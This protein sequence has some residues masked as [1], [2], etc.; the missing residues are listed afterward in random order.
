LQFLDE[1][2]HRLGAF[3]ATVRA[4]LVELDLIEFH[5]GG[6]D[7]VAEVDHDLVSLV[8]VG[9]IEQPLARLGIGVDEGAS[10]ILVLLEP[11]AHRGEAFLRRAGNLCKQELAAGLFKTEAVTREQAGRVDRPGQ[12]C[13]QATI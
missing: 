11:V 13:L 10:S 9:R 4:D 1:V 5:E 7:F 3:E 8:L 2:V 6:W 12:Q